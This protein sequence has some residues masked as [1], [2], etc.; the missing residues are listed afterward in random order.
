[1]KLVQKTLVV[2]MMLALGSSMAYAEP[3]KV[4]IKGSVIQE[5]EGG[6]M[7]NQQLKVHEGV[8]VGGGWGGSGQGEGHA[9]GGLAGGSG[10]AEVYGGTAIRQTQKNGV[11]NNQ[12]IELGGNKDSFGW[13]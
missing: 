6:V 10:S 1:M 2:A 9:A 3:D 13:K 11:M 7:N 4:V 12:Q 5:Q 8:L